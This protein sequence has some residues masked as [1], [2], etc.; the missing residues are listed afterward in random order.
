M[1][2]P[3]FLIRLV[4]IFPLAFAPAVWSAEKGQASGVLIVA[5]K[6]FAFDGGECSHAVLPGWDRIQIKGKTKT[7]EGIDLDLFVSSMDR[8]GGNMEHE[9]YLAETG[10]SLLE[11][12]LYQSESSNEGSGWSN[13]WSEDTGPLIKIDGKTVSASGVFVDR[14]LHKSAGVGTLT[15][16][17]TISLSD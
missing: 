9:V 7:T 5:G 11:G 12:M 17:C 8:G 2:H 16:T 14:K 4:L 1:T 13:L 15:A 6:T 10:K 3:V